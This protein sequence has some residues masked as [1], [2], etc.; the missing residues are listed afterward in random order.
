MVGEETS[1]MGQEKQARSAIKM[2][3]DLYLQDFDR[4]QAV[5]S[6]SSSFVPEHIKFLK[7]LKEL[8]YPQNIYVD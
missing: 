5:E 7:R 1:E 4:Q 6:P 2:F 3:F 8:G